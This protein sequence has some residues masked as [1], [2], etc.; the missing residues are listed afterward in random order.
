M[1]ERMENQVI[2]AK[3]A[4]MASQALQELII[5]VV[6]LRA[7]LVQMAHQDPQAQPV[8]RVPKADPEKQ[9][10]RHNQIHNQEIPDPLGQQVHQV[11]LE[12]QEI[13]V[14][15][16]KPEKQLPETLHQALQVLLGLQV[17]KDLLDRKAI[18]EVDLVKQGQRDHQA[19]K[20]MLAQTEN[21]DLL[22]C[23]ESREK[24]EVQAH[25]INV[26]RPE[27]LLVI[28]LAFFKTIL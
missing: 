27:L 17:Q 16:V 13:K 21:R 10:T 25:A 12:V 7:L 24:K 26:L 2:K 3:M 1:T 28:N 19:T 4:L 5:L 6:H 9:I 8:P 14:H 22:D 11:P 18:L 15:Q 20:G 23:Q